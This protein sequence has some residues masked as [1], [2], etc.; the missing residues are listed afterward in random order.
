MRKAERLF[1]IITLLRGRRTVITAE[2]LALVLEISTRTLYRDIQ[3][4]QLSGVPIEGEA[5]VGYRLRAGF[6]LP[7][8]MFTSDEMLALLVGARMVRAFTDRELAQAAEAAEIK[9]RAIL[10]DKLIQR[11]N[12]Q[13][14]C[15]PIVGEDDHFRCIHLILR[16]GCEQKRAVTI[17]Y[18]SLKSANTQRCVYPLAIIGWRQS[19]MLLA[20]CELRQAYR[21]FRMDRITQASLLDQTFSTGPE[22]SLRHYLRSEL[23]MDH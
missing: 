4:L 21:N 14:Y 19:W 2:Q 18:L 1:Q 11:A 9:I 20:W 16:N 3:A 8:L 17:D 5:G 15:I 13:P 23:Q 7:P 22:L 10:P 12:Q 6:D